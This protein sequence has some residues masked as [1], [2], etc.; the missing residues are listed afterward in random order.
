[1]TRPAAVKP[2]EGVPDLRLVRTGQVRFHEHPEPWRTSRLVERLRSEARL[3]YPPAVAALG[4]G[5]WVL[6]DGANRVSAFREIGWSHVPV[7]V[8][9]YGNA[10]VQLKGW[11]HSLLEGR[12]LD[13]RAA[14]ERLP[15]VR[16][17]RVAEGE[18]TS[19]LELR[20]FY[21]ALVDGDGT[22]WGVYPAEDLVR[23]GPWMETLDHVVAAYEGKSRLERIKIAD[24][25]RLPDI[26][27][28][29]D[30]QLVLFPT[31]S[32]TEL[33]ELV[34]DGIRIPTGLTRHLI[35][36]R[37][38][39]LHLPLGF[40]TELADEEAKVAHFRAFVSGLEMAG[41]IRY[42]EESVFIMSE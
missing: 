36:G 21:A 1:V 31:M 2:I 33:L 5:E 25:E 27:R 11:H 7:Q 24:Y 8:I 28:A 26:L 14:Y 18:L 4:N 37:A 39:G 35:P 17:A 22:V 32:K 19:R 29:V 40:L 9:E 34:R 6:L 38:L 15:G 3:Q 30:H 42:Y 20:Q 16:V 41:R 23:L 12:G 10:G 13:L